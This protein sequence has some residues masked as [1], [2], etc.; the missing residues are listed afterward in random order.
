MEVKEVFPNTSIYILK[1]TK[2][3]QHFNLKNL[4]WKIYEKRRW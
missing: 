1:R 2:Q 3:R 4:I